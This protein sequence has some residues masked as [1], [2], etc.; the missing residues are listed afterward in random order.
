MEFFWRARGWDLGGGEGFGGRISM[1]W[2][3]ILLPQPIR[4]V[5][6]KKIPLFLVKS[7]T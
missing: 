6:P 3:K 4:A 1:E 7:P 5:H 2:K